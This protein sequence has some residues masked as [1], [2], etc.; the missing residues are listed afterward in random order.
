MGRRKNSPQ[1]KYAKQF[2]S[3]LA[4]KERNFAKYGG[5]TPPNPRKG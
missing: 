4:H 2:A 5:N 3:V 1:K